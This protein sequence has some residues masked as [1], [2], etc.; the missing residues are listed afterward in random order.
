MQLE[1]VIR[2]LESEILD[3]KRTEKKLRRY[4]ERLQDLSNRFIDPGEN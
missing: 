1:A 4:S 3:H 2:E